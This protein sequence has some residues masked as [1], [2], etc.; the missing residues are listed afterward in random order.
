MSEIIQPPPVSHQQIVPVK[1]MGGKQ[2]DATIEQHTVRMSTSPKG[3]GDGSGP[4]PKIL[5]LG[6]VGGCTM[7]DVV[8]ILKKM[9]I[10]FASF[11]TEVVAD[12]A[13]AIPAVY[14]LIH[15]KY[16]FS[17]VKPDL[18][19]VHHAVGLSLEKYCSVHAMLSA[20]VEFSHEVI[21]N[22]SV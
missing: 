18:A 14:K 6:A 1:W 21:W 4:S 9:R 19:K 12:V 20:T 13:D 15:I 10:E 11:E 3:G 2:F 8:D 17:G 7:M 16:I 22:E 5:L